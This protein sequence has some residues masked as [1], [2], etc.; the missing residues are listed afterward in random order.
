MLSLFAVAPIVAPHWHPATFLEALISVAAFGCLG[1]AL[2]LLGFKLFEWLTPRID[3]EKELSEKN[4]AV[5]VVLS[6]LFVRLGY[7]VAQLISG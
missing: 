6:A 7:I 4:M 2:L 5:G 1:I 3:F